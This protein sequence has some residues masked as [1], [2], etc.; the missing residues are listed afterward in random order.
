MYSLSCCYKNS[1]SYVGKRLN[2]LKTQWVVGI[3]RYYLCTRECFARMYWSIFGMATLRVT[4]FLLMFWYFFP[5][6]TPHPLLPL[7]SEG[8]LSPELSSCSDFSLY[9]RY[10]D[11]VFL[12]NDFFNSGFTLEYSGELK[13]NSD[14]QCPFLNWLHE[15]TGGG[16]R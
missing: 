15:N 11:L 10:K 6:F 14:T 7:G 1:L 8:V 5:T 13:K 9:L 2:S 12:L 3:N 4:S 16:G